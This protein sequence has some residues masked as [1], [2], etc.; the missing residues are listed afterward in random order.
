M[1]DALDLR[2]VTVIGNSIGGWIAAELGLLAPQT[3]SR[4]VL[5]DAVGIEVPRH[6]VADFF[7]LTPAQVAE[8]SYADPGRF[9]MNPRP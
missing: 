9:G 1:L 4:I 7:A 5:V 3:V 6:P 2:D 8:F